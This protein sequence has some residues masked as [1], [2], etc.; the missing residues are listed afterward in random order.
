MLIYI[1]DIINKEPKYCTAYELLGQA[2][3]VVREHLRRFPLKRNGCLI[4]QTTVFE[5]ER[6]TI[7]PD[8]IASAR[9]VRNA[10]LG[11]MNL[12]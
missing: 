11:L 12:H 5:A 9:E 3:G 10:R 1:V 4:A 2:G 8:V 6:Q 7:A